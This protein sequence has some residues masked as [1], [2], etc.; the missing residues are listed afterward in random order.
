[1]TVI[2]DILL[3]A[4]SIEILVD[5]MIIQRK[6]EVIRAEFNDVVEVFDIRGY[7]FREVDRK[8]SY[9]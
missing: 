6:K 9:R 8:N 7:E 3:H 4:K 1:M 2:E 5:T